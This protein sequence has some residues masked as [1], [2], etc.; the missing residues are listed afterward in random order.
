MSLFSPVPPEGASRR[1]IEENI[2][3]CFQDFLIHLEGNEITGHAGA[4]TLKNQDEESECKYESEECFQSAD[5]T[6][7]GILRLLT[8]EK[9]KLINGENLKITIEFFYG[10]MERNLKHK[11]ICQLLELVVAKLHFLLSTWN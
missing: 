7:A 8:G 4:N 9:Q 11:N 5:L 6:P 1:Q 2:V 10:C 3:H